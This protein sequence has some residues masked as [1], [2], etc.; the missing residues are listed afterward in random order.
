MSLPALPVRIPQV[1]DNQ[2]MVDQVV[3]F[4]PVLP[5]L[6]HERFFL[7][8]P[9]PQGFVIAGH[10]DLARELVAV[11]GSNL[12]GFGFWIRYVDHAKGDEAGTS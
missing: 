12:R 7:I 9:F 5:Q 3:I 1:C 11:H 8:V 4:I 10:L 2:R 6:I